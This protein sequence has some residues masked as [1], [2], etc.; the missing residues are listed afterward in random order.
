MLFKEQ[1]VDVTGPYLRCKNLKIDTQISIDCL[2]PPFQVF[3]LME[4]NAFLL[5]HL[6]LYYIRSIY[7]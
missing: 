2:D 7:H 3:V 4:V 6:F 5:Q 1:T